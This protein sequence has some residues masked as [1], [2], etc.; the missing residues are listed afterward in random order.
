MTQHQQWMGMWR[1]YMG[2]MK[3]NGRRPSKYKTRDMH[4]VNWLKYNRKRR[5]KGLLPP[6]RC[7]LLDQLYA[8]ADRLKQARAEA[9]AKELN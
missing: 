8:E 6:D 2:Y 3:R 1:R 5:N 7:A 9:K 4:L